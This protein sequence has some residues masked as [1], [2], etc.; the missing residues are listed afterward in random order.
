MNSKF[1]LRGSLFALI[2]VA[3]I[4]IIT[5]FFLPQILL[6]LSNGVPIGPTP[7]PPII[8]A[9]RGE[10][11]AGPGGL[12]E[13]TQ[14]RGEAYN[15]SGS[16]FLLQLSNGEVVGVTT[17]HSVSIG[18][19]NRP[20]ERIA[21]KVAGQKEVAAEFETLHGK[22]G[23][24]RTG[25]DMTVDYV[26]LK[27]DIPVDSS[28]VLTP[29]SRGVPQV[30]E[31]VSMFSGLGD[32][33]GGRRILQGTVLSVDTTAVW[34]LM[35]EW[36]DPGRMSG[37]PL[38]SRHTG[39]VVGTAIAVSPRGGRLTIGFHPIGSIVRLAEAADEFP[40]MADYRR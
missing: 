34:V 7:L 22:P 27:V 36:F 39:Q 8:L 6:R 2:V 10:M 23:Q 26:L 38:I 16:G 19:P 24:P 4:L 25:T 21:F 12:E 13:W 9:S 14:Y 31:R 32:G 30:G 29:D 40:A 35:D 37:S 1:I 5:W 15:L 20:L 28:L 33:N 3:V 11:P 18:D 17:A